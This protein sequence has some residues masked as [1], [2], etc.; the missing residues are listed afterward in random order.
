MN[1]SI[2]PFQLIVVAQIIIYLPLPFMIYPSRI[3]YH[4]TPDLLPAAIF[5]A[6][7]NSVRAFS[8]PSNFTRLLL[9]NSDDTR[10]C[11]AINEYELYFGR[12]KIGYC[13]RKRDEKI[14]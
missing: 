1:A 10:H 11:Y 4:Y 8:T 2:N 9:L 12:V 6:S 3:K 14:Y 5:V 7:G 13:S